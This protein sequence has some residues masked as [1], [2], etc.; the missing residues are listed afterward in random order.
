ML[1]INYCYYYE[2]KYMLREG[3]VYV[4]WH[5]AAYLCSDQVYQIEYF[6]EQG[7]GK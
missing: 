2:V 6:R 5:I 3:N 1:T 4:I 7:R